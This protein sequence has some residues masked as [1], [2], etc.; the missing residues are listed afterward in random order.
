VSAPLKQRH[1]WDSREQHPVLGAP[2]LASL[3]VTLPMLLSLLVTLPM[4]LSPLLYSLH[5][6]RLNP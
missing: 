3:L 4:L 1:Y 5:P 2:F 6:N